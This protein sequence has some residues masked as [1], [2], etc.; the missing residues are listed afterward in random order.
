[1]TVAA[2]LAQLYIITGIN[3]VST[4]QDQTET[5]VLDSAQTEQCWKQKIGSGNTHIDISIQVL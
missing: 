5:P 1:M 4:Q 3:F 2:I